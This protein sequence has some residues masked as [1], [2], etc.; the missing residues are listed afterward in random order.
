[1]KNYVYKKKTGYICLLI[2]IMSLFLYR[3]FLTEA[4]MGYAFITY[5][6]CTAVWMIFGQGFSDVTARMARVRLSK[7][8]KRSA[9]DVLSVSFAC[10]F[11][12][13]LIGTALCGALNFWFMSDVIN[14]P[15]GRFLGLY[16]CG[17]FFFRMMNE[18]LTG[19]ASV[20]SG[21]RAICISM[22]SRE[23]FRIVF[24]FLLMKMMYDKGIVNSA[25]LM[26]EDI[27]YIY[28]CAGL[29]AGFCV[30]E[31]FVFVFLFIVRLGLR[32]KASDEREGFGGRDNLGVVIIN[33]LK[34]RVGDLVAG[35][36]VCLVLLI[37][38]AQSGDVHGIG[39]SVY[40]LLSPFAF[41][42]VFA[43]YA[44]S[45]AGANWMQSVR[46][47]EKGNARAYFDFG[48]HIVCIVSVFI[49][50]FFASVSKP[51]AKLLSTGSESS[52]IV[53]FILIIA[54]S[55]MLSMAMF[56][57]SLCSGRDDRIPR[58]IAHVASGFAGILA[59]KLST[60]NGHNMYKG[61]MI[62]V[63]VYSLVEL[64]IWCVIS[65]VRMSMVFDPIRNILIPIVSGAVCAIFLV[66]ITN[67]AAAH[68]GNLFT[69]V[70]C[71]PIGLIIYH[72]VLLLLRNYSDAELKLMPFGS[73]L[74]SLGQI[75]KVI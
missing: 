70:I 56:C 46:K 8:Q 22:V 1:M 75:L 11:I 29:F 63:L 66:I 59:V 38:A 45:H 15:K 23:L 27:K 54:A 42:L 34:R 62:S 21:D 14:L 25:L 39:L 33:L 47:N 52:L 44:G 13:G 67:A 20:S 19:Y 7:G 12:A 3:M 37:W 2:S 41:S 36:S 43:L 5:L 72:S 18:Y 31:I 69:V 60:G 73:V 53:E 26:D 6:V 28:A 24:G 30:A 51:V 10:H 68:L 4:G 74:Y 58:I 64:I 57:D 65:Y 32:I 40:M 17:C 35:L 16:L 55:I 61:L 49:T 9:L 71:I 50:A 48:M